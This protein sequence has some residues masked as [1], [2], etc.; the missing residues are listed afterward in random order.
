MR[1][2]HLYYSSEYSEEQIWF[3]GGRTIKHAKKNKRNHLVWL[4]Q[5]LLYP[6]QDEISS[7]RYKWASSWSDTH[8]VAFN[9]PWDAKI[10]EPTE[11]WKQKHNC[12]TYFRKTCMGNPLQIKA[13]NTHTHTVYTNYT[14][15]LPHQQL[16]LCVHN[17]ILPIHPRIK[18]WDM[19]DGVKLGPHFVNI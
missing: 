1:N 19:G 14:R 18:R 10:A 16:R 5:I 8:G 17:N 7:W 2:K 4:L 11:R 13:L 3:L 6:K 12:S 15:F 9:H